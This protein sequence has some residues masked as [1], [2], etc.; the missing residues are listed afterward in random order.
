MERYAPV[1][2]LSFPSCITPI[3][4]LA[5]RVD[6]P[7]RCLEWAFWIGLISSIFSSASSHRCHRNA[8]RQSIDNSGPWPNAALPKLPNPRQHR[9]GRCQKKIHRACDGPDEKDRWSRI[10]EPDDY[11]SIYSA[12]S[13][14]NGILPQRWQEARL[15]SE[16]DHIAPKLEKIGGF[17]REQWLEQAVVQ[18]IRVLAW[19][20]LADR[21]LHFRFTPEYENICFCLMALTYIPWPCQALVSDHPAFQSRSV[22]KH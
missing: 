16:H 5:H 19:V 15:A 12:N 14:V 17:P 7:F 6:S 1:C 3:L 8:L 4:C 21:E 20:G 11:A 22:S 2:Y 9:R 10:G 18:H 13:S